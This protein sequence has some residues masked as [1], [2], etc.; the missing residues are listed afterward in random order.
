MRAAR[1][2]RVELLRVAEPEKAENGVLRT[3]YHDAAVVCM[4]SAIAIGV[5]LH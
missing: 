1:K 2:P 3:K 4:L 5:I